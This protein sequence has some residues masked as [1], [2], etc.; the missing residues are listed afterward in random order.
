M[1]KLFQAFI[2][3]MIISCS[4]SSSVFAANWKD[5]TFVN[6]TGRT[7]YYIFFNHISDSDWGGDFL[8]DKGILS[9]GESITCRYN[10]YY[11]FFDFKVVFSANRSSSDN[12]Y[13]REYNFS[14]AWRI[15]IY[16]DGSGGYRA[17]K[18]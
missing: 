10:A 13:W 2:L 5:V 11:T 18:N 17:V 7:I 1:K 4:L 12:A 9:P 16:S 6:H 14:G 3:S 15:T 8:H